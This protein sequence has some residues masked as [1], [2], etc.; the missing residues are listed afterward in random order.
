MG[1]RAHPVHGLKSSES[2]PSWLHWLQ[3]NA[4]GWRWMYSQAG[5]NSAIRLP[6]ISLSPGLR[7]ALS[8]SSRL[9]PS[10]FP[11]K[12]SNLRSIAIDPQVANA[13]APFFYNV[14]QPQRHLHQH[15]PH[16]VFLQAIP[17]V[18]TGF[19]EAW[20]GT[21]ASRFFTERMFYLFN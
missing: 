12:P 11:A 16:R 9:L 21:A 19:P 2:I 5:S 4:D 13:S 14:C 18:E 6:A 10:R 8:L 3:N 20:P 7:T 17:T 15:P 1:T